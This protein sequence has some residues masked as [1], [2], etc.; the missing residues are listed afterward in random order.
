MQPVH[1]CDI[2]SYDK[3]LYKSWNHILEDPNVDDLGLDCCVYHTHG[4]NEL[5]KVDLLPDGQNVQ[6]TN[7][8]KNQ[9]LT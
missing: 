5:Q 3:E 7:D 6:L 9:Y 8:N 4:D 1:L 2:Y